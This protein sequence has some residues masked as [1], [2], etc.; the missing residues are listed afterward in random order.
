LIE[1][2][3]AGSA[4]PTELRSHLDACASCRSALTEELQ[5]FAAIDAGLRATANA[6]VS[7]SFLPRIRV[8]LEDASASERRWRPSLIF[9][10]AAAATVVT[11]FIA[12]RPRHAMNDNQAN[13]TVASPTREKLATPPRREP[14]ESPVMVGSTGLHHIQRRRHSN[15]PRSASSDQLEVLVP[16]EEREAFARF[17]NAQRERNGVVI[18]VVVPASD[19]EDKPSSMKPLQIAKL[20]VSP[21]EPLEGDAPNSMDERH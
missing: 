17:V 8:R 16:P 19:E 21:L 1:A 13:H 6:E 10:A 3:A 2:A 14:A 12:A 18:S 20:V 9:A 15:S 4:P 5:L 7:P 11:V